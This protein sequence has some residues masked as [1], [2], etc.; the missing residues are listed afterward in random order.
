M[1]NTPVVLLYVRGQTAEREVSDILFAT[2]PESVARLVFV[3]V[4]APERVL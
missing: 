3:F 4:S 1:P 2:I